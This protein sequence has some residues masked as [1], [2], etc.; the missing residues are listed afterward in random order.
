MRVPLIKPVLAVIARLDTTGTWAANPAGSP[1]AGYDP[2]FREPYPVHQ[3]ANFT[4][5][6]VY[7]A[8]VYVPCQFR[9]KRYGEERTTFGGDAPLTNFVFVFHR[10]DLE[11]LSLLGSDRNPLLKKGDKIVR[12]LNKRG[13][14]VFTPELPLYIYRLD[15]ASQGFGPDGFD[16]HIATTTERSNEPMGR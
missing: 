12:V 3:G 15:P 13:A 6:R 2:D 11:R 4:D 10:K 5:A 1:T 7:M 14:T 8:E 9:T 16:I